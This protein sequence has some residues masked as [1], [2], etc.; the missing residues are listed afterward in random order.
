[1]FGAVDRQR[2]GVGG[3]TLHRQAQSQGFFDGTL[4]HHAPSSRLGSHQNR[5]GIEWRCPRHPHRR[6]DFRKTPQG[7]FGSICRQ[8]RRVFPA[9]GDMGLIGRDAPHAHFGQAVHHFEHIHMA[10][11]VDQFGR[12]TSRGE[13]QQRLAGN[14]DIGQHM[15]KLQRIKRHRLWRHRQIDAVAGDKRIERV[16]IRFESAIE[17]DHAPGLDA[18]RRLRIV[19]TISDGQA[20]LGPRLDKRFFVDITL[21]QGTKT[22]E[23]G[24]GG[25]LLVWEFVS[26][27]TIHKK[28]R[29]GVIH[30][31]VERDK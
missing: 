19:G 13:A 22:E 11:D 14:V 17:L 15:R 26:S 23:I 18:Q 31:A 24:H 20:G 30:L 12:R 3:Q 7:G 28:P 6:L 5:Q 16:E 27:P 10:H 1:M 9:V 4:G 25:L 8:E 29:Q 21:I 2:F